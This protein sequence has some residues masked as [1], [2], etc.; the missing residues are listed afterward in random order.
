ME[1]DPILW[2]THG[3][4]M[5]V[6]WGLFAPLAV[7]AA[8]LR[9]L[10]ERLAGEQHKG[11]WFTLH[12]SLNLM[13]LL[14]SI[15]GISI[16]YIAK[17]QEGETSIEGIHGQV[18]VALAVLLVVQFVVGYFRP[19]LPPPDATAKEPT[20][21]GLDEI[22]R[23]DAAKL[24]GTVATEKS[25]MRTKWEVFHRAN[26]I[27]LL[28]MAW[29]NCHTGIIDTVESYENY[30]DWTPLFWGVVGVLT[31]LIV[32]GKVWLKVTSK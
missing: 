4:F 22:E 26:G 31:A 29:Y 7:G 20:D 13:V 30:M 17:S 27:A 5:G 8:V 18:G 25:S 16:A 24:D 6:A 19:A 23:S 10:V 15:V 2:K 28:G 32:F 3:I 21:D 12:V 11:L 1:A 14:L 9:V